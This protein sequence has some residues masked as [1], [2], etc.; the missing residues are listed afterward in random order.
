MLVGINAYPVRT[1]EPLKDFTPLDGCV[2]DA[3]VIADFLV[4]RRGFASSAI[5]KLTDAAATREAIMSALRWLVRGAKAGDRL[6]FSY[7]GHGTPYPLTSSSTRHH[8]L[9][10]AI[11]PVDFGTRRSSLI[12]DL[13]FEE[14]FRRLPAGVEFIWICD[15]CFSGGLARDFRLA[16]EEGRRLRTV[17]LRH[18][19]AR[20]MKAARKKRGGA[21]T[22]VRALAPRLN[23]AIIVAATAEQYSWDWSF[24]R[25]ARAHGVLTHYLLKA[26]N[27]RDGHRVPL[28]ELLRRVAA[29]VRRSRSAYRTQHPE[30]M[31][32]PSALTRPFF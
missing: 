10:D 27:A 1:T 12:T 7:S 9:I 18:T 28:D 26:L 30:V 16:R 11:C 15:S 20:A 2:N 21:P 23:G 5:R 3:E 6:L 8:P 17:K 14:V 19:V 22:G 32:S 29:T 24:G 13:D 4:Q 31:G 25:P